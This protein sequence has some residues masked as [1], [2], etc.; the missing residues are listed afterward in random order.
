[1]ETI[2]QKNIVLRP[3][4]ER[5]LCLILEWSLLP[6]QIMLDACLG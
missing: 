5:G 4:T 1:M 2:A 3:L 6:V